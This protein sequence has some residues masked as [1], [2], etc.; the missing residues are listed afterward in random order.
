[1]RPPARSWVTWRVVLAAVLLW[2]ADRAWDLYDWLAGVAMRIQVPRGPAARGLVRLGLL[3]VLSGASLTA[4]LAWGVR[5]TAE[6][7]G[8]EAG[9]A[10]LA[11]A[12]RPGD[13][14]AAAARGC[15]EGG[16]TFWMGEEAGVVVAR[17]RPF[18][19]VGVAP[20]AATRKVGR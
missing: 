17:C 5:G 19:S 7:P 6:R 20:V 8:V 1:M 18:L 2:V 11:P 16:G 10:E 9:R 4:G 3:A 13:L 15:V 14:M 12:E